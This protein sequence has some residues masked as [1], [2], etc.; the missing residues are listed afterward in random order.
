MFSGVVV[1]DQCGGA[2]CA[3]REIPLIPRLGMGP[4]TQALPQTPV[5]WIYEIR[6]IHCGH[7]QHQPQEVE[8]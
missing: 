2:E 5:Q 8:E 6:C 3:V 4:R 1:C 7:I